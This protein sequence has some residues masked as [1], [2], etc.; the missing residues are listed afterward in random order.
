M[1]FTSVEFFVFVALSLLAF[2]LAPSLRARRWV[3]A[4][5]NAVFM[6]VLVAS[7][8]LLVPMA[9]FLVCGFV[10]VRVAQA[11]QSRPLTVA[12]IVITVG[13]FV[14]FKGY[15]V[16]DFLPPLLEPYSVVGLS[17]VLF[18]VLHL[19]VDGYN[20]AI[21]TPVPFLLFL[22]YCC[23]FLSWLSGP[24]QRYEEFLEQESHLAN[25]PMSTGL[26]WDAFSRI[27]TGYFKLALLS[28]FLVDLHEFLAALP[29]SGAGTLRLGTILGGAAASYTLYMYYNFAG[30]MDVVIGLGT[31]YGFR[32]PEN[33]DRPF[34]S[35]NFLE[36]W[37][38]W[39][40]TLSNWFKFYVFNPAT[41]ALVSRWG[42]RRATPYLGVVAYFVTFATM[43][44]W[45][46]ST[47]IF[48]V[49]GLFLGSGVSL[50]KLY[51]IEGRRLLGKQAFGRLRANG[52]YAALCRGLVFT[53]FATALMC[54]WMTPRTFGHVVQNPLGAVVAFLVAAV[55][56]AVILETGGR[57]RS[58]SAG[59]RVTFQRIT[60]GDAARPVWV[61]I[62]AYAILLLILMNTTG[63]PTFVYVPF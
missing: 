8:T 13:A 4:A 18:R 47:P 7:P 59:A 61:G 1:Y 50:N 6:A 15:S 31:L 2:H 43:G 44:I 24:I 38:R 53:Y 20:G 12:S 29:L 60:Q 17:Y 57:A 51:E 16:V 9:V 42:T 21:R 62:K 25:P 54:F 3:L 33:F 35:G 49:Y 39:H 48:F 34:A 56:A 52:P 14:F 37:S 30:Y 32:L 58:A 10:F 11:R 5:S 23:S 26:V 46:G 28:G 55:F 40:I 22:N 36:F 27:A 63:V 45:H 19:L 41:K